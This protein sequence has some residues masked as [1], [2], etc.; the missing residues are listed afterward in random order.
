MRK[1]V[2]AIHEHV[3]ADWP[4]SDRRFLDCTRSADKPAEFKIAKVYHRFRDVPQIKDS[5]GD[6]WKP[7][8]RFLTEGGDCE[9]FVTCWGLALRR[10]GFE[11]NHMSVVWI[12]DRHQLLPHVVLVVKADGLRWALDNQLQDIVA[13]SKLWLKAPGEAQPRYKRMG[14][15][16]WPTA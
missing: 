12:W 5:P 7:P 14:A 13:A 2:T 9:D 8:K 15:T 3:A 6:E 16:L 1:L 4:L 11:A 10:V